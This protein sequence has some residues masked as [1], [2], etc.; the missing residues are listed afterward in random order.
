[1]FAPFSRKPLAK[2]TSDFF[3]FSRPQPWSPPFVAR[4]IADRWKK[5]LNSASFWPKAEPVSAAL[6]ASTGAFHLRRTI[7]CFDHGEKL[8]SIR[9]KILEDLHRTALGRP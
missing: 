5:M 9:R 7:K 2:Y 4:P 3:S 8:G 6:V 1:L